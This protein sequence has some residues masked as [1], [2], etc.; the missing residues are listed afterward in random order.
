MGTRIKAVLF[1]VVFRGARASYPSRVRGLKYEKIFRKEC[2]RGSY[3]SWVRGLKFTIMDI[4]RQ[5]EISY[6]YGYED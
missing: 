3:P 2:K 6:L 1:A 5:K 4:T